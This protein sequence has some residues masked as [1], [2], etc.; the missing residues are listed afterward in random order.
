[1]LR[2]F[3]TLGIRWRHV[4]RAGDCVFARDPRSLSG[5]FLL[6]LSALVSSNRSRCSLCRPLCLQV[7]GLV[8]YRRIPTANNRAGG[9]AFYGR[10][11]PSDLGNHIK[12]PLGIR[13]RVR[14]ERDFRRPCELAAHGLGF[15]LALYIELVTIGGSNGCLRE[16][17]G[18]LW[19]W[20]LGRVAMTLVVSILFLG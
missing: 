9:R 20:I 11:G 4:R 3:L 2:S 5:M 17:D 12:P 8:H 14:L 1:M 15:V 6:L 7:V 13:R 10:I 19:D 18:K 16:I